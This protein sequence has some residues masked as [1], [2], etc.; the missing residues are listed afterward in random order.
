MGYHGGVAGTSRSPAMLAVAIAFSAVIIV[1]VGLAR[2]GEGFI[3]V[4]QRPLV[5]LRGVLAYDAKP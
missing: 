4:S 2:P 1:I 3:N 5:D